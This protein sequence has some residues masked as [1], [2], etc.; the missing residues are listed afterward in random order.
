MSLTLAIQTVVEQNLPYFKR[1]FMKNITYLVIG[2]F[3]LSLSTQSKASITLFE[4]GFNIDG[5][6]TSSGIDDLPG[7][8]MLDGSGLGSIAFDVVGAGDHFVKAYFDFEFDEGNNSF[9]NEFA[10]TGG[11]LDAGQSFE[12]DEPGD[13][14]GDIF[15]NFSSSSAMFD[16]ENAVP[17]SA[18]DDVSFGIAWNFSLAANQT[19]TLSFSL[20]EVLSALPNAFFI[21]HVDPDIAPNSGVPSSLFFSSNL[22]I[23]S[24]NNPPGNVS[25]PSAVAL[26]LAGLLILVRRRAQ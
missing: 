6:V 12:I 26:L 2:L 20:A 4:W 25:S 24:I 21:E 18:P 23:S 5:T 22:N 16:N 7:N 15:D 11:V 14:F 10:R 3:A 17:E 19:A 1:D 13:V 9:F 8:S